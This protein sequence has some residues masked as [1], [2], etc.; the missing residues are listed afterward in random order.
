MIAVVK[1]RIC[2]STPMVVLI[3]FDKDRGG[4]RWNRVFK[5]SNPDKK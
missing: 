3:S 5:S 4:V 1:L 2:P